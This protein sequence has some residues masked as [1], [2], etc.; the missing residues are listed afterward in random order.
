MAS[1]L[2][3]TPL[4]GGRQRIATAT[5][6]QRLHMNEHT[7]TATLSSF[8]EPRISIDYFV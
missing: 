2:S 8:C 7:A 3:L 1:P 5:A 6:P 4:L